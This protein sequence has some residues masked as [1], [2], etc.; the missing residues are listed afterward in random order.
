MSFVDE[1]SL[2]DSS[3]YEFERLIFRLL[4]H[5]GWSGLIFTSRSNDKGADLVGMPPRSQK[6][7]VIQC[8]HTASSV[9]GKQGVDDLVRAC[10]FYEVQ[11]GILA[12]N[13]RLSGAAKDRIAQLKG[14]YR[15]QV[16]DYAQLLA[17][18][19][20]LRATSASRREPREYQL[21]AIEKALD[22]FNQ[23]MRRGMATFATGLG[24]SILLGEI[25]VEYAESR[26][27]PVLVLADRVPLIE[28]LEASIWPQ[29]GPGTRTRLW[30]GARKP[31]Q[32]DGITVATQQSVYSYLKRGGELPQFGAVLID[33]CHHAAS[34]TYRE[35]IELLEFD[36][37]FGVTAT[38]WRGDAQNLTEVFGEVIAE[39]GLVEGIRR[40]FLAD[41]DY[42]MFFDNVD[43]ETVAQNSQARLS[44]KDLNARLFLPARD[45]DLC[46]SAISEW[47]NSGQPKTITFCRS[48]D[49]AERLAELFTVLGMPSK[50][51]HSRDMHRTEQA[52]ILMQ[53]RSGQ[54]SNL[55]SVDILNEGI[56]LPDVGMVIFA[57]VT[58]SRRIFVQQLGRGLRVTK[59][60]DCVRVLDFVAD[61]RRLA[62]GVRMNQESRDLARRVEHYR[63]VGA[64]LISFARERHGRFVEEYL[65]DVADLGENDKI[66]LDFLV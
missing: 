55:V 46:A 35:T 8:K 5:A 61:V 36:L 37:L 59:E 27:L 31:R 11:H 20:K 38:P 26:D 65:A 34:S 10:D 25:A 43:W 57:R 19:G 48:I 50:P 16:W 2:L 53:F 7:V 29:L 3:W 39:M 58:H 21:L 33:E 41:V 42:T 24:K 45:E 54:F 30:D 28:Q 40:G 62:E 14:Q 12:T 18:G 9:V 47:N 49:H 4:Q 15:I 63:G 22:S 44:I 32:F 17:F 52:L 66:S 56:D 51:I 13:A 23:G 64:D 6:Y 1:T 60:K